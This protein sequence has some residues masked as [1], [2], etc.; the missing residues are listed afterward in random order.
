[1]PDSR[2]PQPECSNKQGL[3][4]HPVNERR[5]LYRLFGWIALAVAAG[6]TL[7]WA[8]PRAY[9]LFPRAWEVSKADAASIALERLGDLGELPSRPYVTTRI[10]SQAELEHRLQ[11]SAGERPAREIWASRLARGLMYWE[12][13]VYEHDARARDWTYRARITPHGEVVELRL[14]VPPEV[15]GGTIEPAVARQR[16][17]LFLREQGLDLGSYREPEVRTQQL[18]SRT[19]LFLRYRDR[20]A[21][22]GTEHPYGIEVA[23]AGDQLAGYSTY[24]DDPDRAAIQ[25]TFRPLL[26]LNQGWIFIALLLVPVVAVPFVRRY[27][28]GEIGVRRGVQIGL[29]VVASGVVTMFLCGRAASAGWGIG[30]LT[31]PQVAWV[32]VFQMLV[33][34][35]FPMALMAFLSWSVGE[36]LTRERWSGKL[37]AFDALF[38]GDW[39]NATFAWSTLR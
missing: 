31:R 12:T 24:Y 37:A 22:L 20:E 29:V 14:R 27:H 11:V 21:F 15:D 10:D 30:V 35:F 28:A 23:F 5:T 8:F 4:K 17:D 32:V 25:S 6:L 7:S 39:L 19:D 13:R 26:L 3:S 1:M 33:L 36:S 18:Q 9:P 2:S 34:F 16:A 38:R